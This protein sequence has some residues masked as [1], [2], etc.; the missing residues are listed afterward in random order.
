M[1]LWCELHNPGGVKGG[2]T[3]FD[4][5]EYEG[6]VAWLQQVSQDELVQVG[7]GGGGGM[8]RG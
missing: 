6:D 8:L 1:M 7:G 5:S 2:I 4:A 3:N